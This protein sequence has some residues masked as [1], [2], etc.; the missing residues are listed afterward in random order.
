VHRSIRAFFV[1][2]LSG[3][4]LLALA[5]SPAHAI[6]ALQLYCPDAVYDTSLETWVITDDTFELW[7]V[8]DVG[9]VGTIYDVDLAASFYGSSGSISITP[10]SPTATPTIDLNPSDAGGYN[11]IIT[12]D[13]YAKA[14]SH[15][16]WSLGDLSNTDSV[17]QDYSPGGT[18]T[19]TGTILKYMVHVSGYEAVHFDAFDHYYTGTGGGSSAGYMTHYVFAPFSHDATGGGTPPTDAPEPSGIWMIAAGIAGLMATRGRGKKK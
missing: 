12:H 18:G 13:E 5:A 17:I 3:V 15:Q 9:R 4:A 1:S 6:P 8:G 19:S 14:D 2:A 10:I 7:V 11:N 16:F